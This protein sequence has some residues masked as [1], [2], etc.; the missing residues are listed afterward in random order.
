MRATSPAEPPRDAGDAL[1]PPPA[2]ALGYSTAEVA[3]ALDLDPARVRGYVR[4][5]LVAPARGPRGEFRFAFADLVRMRAAKRLAAM[6]LPAR[7]IR[8][9]LARVERGLSD[10]RALAALRFSLEGGELVV[11]RG[12]E[13][14]NAESGQ[15]LLELDLA[16]PPAPPEAQ[17]VPIDEIAAR[18]ARTRRPGQAEEHFERGCE[19]EAA[20]ARGAESAYERALEIDPG[21]AEARLNLGRLHHEAGR[22]DAAETCYLRVLE[23]RPGDATAAFNLGVV[24]QDGGR[25]EQAMQAYRLAIAAD[26]AHGDAYFNLAG[27]HEEM[28]ERA[29]AIRV[30]KGY[31]A[32]LRG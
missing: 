27:L 18:R 23:L 11:R 32:V 21:H 16:P 3:R 12:R 14:W 7:R 25:R 24:L 5:A 19:L 13:A 30:L 29:E 22:L 17:V 15:R 10:G 1:F 28:G 6:E 26:P 9:A 31:R 20:D 8:R 4:S 2:S